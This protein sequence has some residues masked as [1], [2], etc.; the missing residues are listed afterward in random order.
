[1][2]RCGFG[3]QST[4]PNVGWFWGN[5]RVAERMNASVWPTKDSYGAERAPEKGQCVSFILAL[6]TPNFQGHPEHPVC[7]GKWGKYE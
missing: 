5:L 6:S 4:K 3:S 2:D 7:A 1:M